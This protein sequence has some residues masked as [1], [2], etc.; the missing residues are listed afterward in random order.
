MFTNG[1]TIIDVLFKREEALSIQIKLDIRQ[2][3]TVQWAELVHVGNYGGCRCIARCRDSKLDVLSG[4]SST[5]SLRNHKKHSGQI[6]VDNRCDVHGNLGGVVRI[7]AKGNLS[8]PLVRGRE[9]EWNG[10]G[11]LECECASGVYL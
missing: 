8:Q 7:T 6:G 11:I 9:R 2:F 1:S 4:C 10:L 5:T 3:L